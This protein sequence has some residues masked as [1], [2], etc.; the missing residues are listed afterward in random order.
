MQGFLLTR[1]LMY[2]LKQIIF[3]MHL[4]MSVGIFDTKFQILLCFIFQ[5]LA[6]AV[7]Y[8]NSNE[9]DTTTKY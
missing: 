3:H 6:L 7:F 9:I 4:Y 1:K 2:E 8:T 5:N